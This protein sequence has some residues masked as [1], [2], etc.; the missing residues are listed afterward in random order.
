M[1]V[2]TQLSA[3]AFTALWILDSLRRGANT[4]TSLLGSLALAGISLGAATLHLGRPAYAWRALKGLR[5][6][7]LS[8]EVLSL[9]LFANLAGLYAGM[10]YLHLPG[11][12]V[13]GFGMVAW[14]ALGV[15][16]SAR[17]YIVPARPA[18]NSRY[19][20]AEFFSTGLLLGPLFVLAL[21]HSALSEV[22]R[23]WLVRAAVVGGTA[24][25]LTQTLKLLWM[26]RSEYFE[27]QA[28]ALLLS[29][30]LRRA[31]LL[32]LGLLIVAGIVLPLEADST[33]I[34]AAALALALGGELL[35][36][37]LFFVSVVPKNIAAAFTTLGRAA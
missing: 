31:F 5:R 9:S 30:L 35:G 12:T 16:C 10:R 37:W 34:A 3:G 36:R 6:S 19:T 18:W 2:L 15:M 17:I 32:R 21:D 7:W 28:S 26:S 25:L 29:G 13:V 11:Q 20:L 27:L 23:I 14:G 4:W 24:Q 33:P 8:R 22:G 1:L